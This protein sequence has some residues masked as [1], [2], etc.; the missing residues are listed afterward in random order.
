MLADKAG[1]KTIYVLAAFLG[2]LLLAGFFLRHTM[3]AILTAMVLSYLLNPLLKYIEKRG[4]DRITGIILIYGCAAFV[5]MLAIVFFIPYINHQFNS[6]I[7]ALPTYLQHMKLAVAEIKARVAPYYMSSE[8]E[9][10]AKRAEE[11]LQRL[12]QDLSGHGFERIKGLAFGLFNLILAPIMVFFMLLYKEYFKSILLW[13][14]PYSEKEH[15]AAMG[16]RINRTLERFIT[17]MVLDCLL[18][19]ILSATALYLLGIEFPLINGMFAGFASIVPFLGV[20]VAIIPPALLGYAKSGDMTMIPKVCA[21]YFLIHV[22]IEGNLV[23]P[24]IMKSTL[25]LN[26]LTVI[27]ALMAMGELLGFWGV[28]LAIPV[29]AVIKICANEVRGLLKEDG[30]L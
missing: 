22:I 18:V 2:V 24:L 30:V 29:A 27:F 15:L 4:F 10:L 3:S 12:S 5:A 20:L 13:A 8:G 28:V 23:K 6:L 26:P 11:S 14:L 1:I 9:W 7:Q 21:A 16:T 25:K 19:G 17:A